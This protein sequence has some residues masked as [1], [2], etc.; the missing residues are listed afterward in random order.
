[1]FRKQ[2][3]SSKYLVFGAALV[4]G[5]SGAALADDNSMTRFGGSG[6]A[7]FHQDKPAISNAPSAF[8]EAD[9]HWPSINEFQALASDGRPWQLPNPSDATVIASMDA[10]KAWRQS[11]PH[12]LPLSVYEA[13]SA[14]GRPWPLPNSSDASAVASTDAAP[15]SMGASE[16]GIA[17]LFGFLR[18]GRTNSA[19]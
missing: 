17:R 16:T 7:Y 15:V 6:Y 19:N 14:D 8:R 5:A 9:A 13:L 4:L 18:A 11:H 10:A 12:G 2:F 3:S 1:M